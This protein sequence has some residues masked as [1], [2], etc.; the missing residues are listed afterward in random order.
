MSASARRSFPP[1][2]PRWRGPRHWAGEV[3]RLG[4]RKTIEAGAFPAS[5]RFERQQIRY[6]ARERPP[7]LGRETFSRIQSPQ[8]WPG[9]AQKIM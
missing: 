1:G 7:L 2:S 9:T 6:S 4:T 8:P 5:I 3:S